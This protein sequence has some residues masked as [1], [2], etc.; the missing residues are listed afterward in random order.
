[1]PGKNNVS[2]LL[3]IVCLASMVLNIWL[4]GFVLGTKADEYRHGHDGKGSRFERRVQMLT[5]DLAP[6]TQ[7]QFM[8]NMKNYM[9][10][11][12]EFRNKLEDLNYKLAESIK[13]ENVDV[14]TAHE[15][16]AEIRSSFAQVHMKFHQGFLKA[17]QELSPEDR[18]AIAEALEKKKY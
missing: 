15:T 3:M 5:K 8:V 16:L 4:I 1:M 12:G 9:P 6:A 11:E 17:V 14:E 2:K 18:D 13:G 10:D 7:K